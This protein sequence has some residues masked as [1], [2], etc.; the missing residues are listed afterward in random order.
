MISSDL[1]GIDE[2]GVSLFF[3][4]SCSPF[5]YDLPSSASTCPI[6]MFTF[7]L[8]FR[9]KPDSHSVGLSIPL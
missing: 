9:P 7:R 3:L 5:G 6:M 4:G 2:V 1:A 8:T